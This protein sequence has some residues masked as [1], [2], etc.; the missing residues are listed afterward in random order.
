MIRYILAA[1][2]FGSMV[3][4][5]A[6][7]QDFADDYGCGRIFVQR[8]SCPPPVYYQCPPTYYQAP[9]TVYVEP[10]VK[11]DIYNNDYVSSKFYV[12][13]R[14]P[15][16]NYKCEIPVINGYLPSVDVTTDSY[17]R[18][19]RL[20]LDYR[21]KEFKYDH[22]SHKSE[23]VY[24]KNGGSSG[25]VGSPLPKRPAPKV[26]ESVTGGSTDPL[27]KPMPKIEDKGSPA[28]AP[29]EKRPAPKLFD[30]KGSLPSPAPATKDQKIE[31]LL[32]ELRGSGE[33][34]SSNVGSSPA[35]PKVEALP[36]G[37]MRP[38]DVTQPEV[39]KTKKFPRYDDK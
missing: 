20:A 18:V 22:Y 5:T 35:A 29:V 36:S 12:K 9:P 15:D 6:S 38:S 34:K 10:A 13:A 21:S 2:L 3:A 1:A 31:E 30:D 39:E 32:R 37:V 7:A 28:P 17:G 14:F 16:Y 8:Y 4:T 27:K 25:S 19:T 11:H 33:F 26:T 24:S 23:I